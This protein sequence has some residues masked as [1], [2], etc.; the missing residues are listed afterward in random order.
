MIDVYNSFVQTSSNDS[1]YYEG[2]QHKL[3]VI[4]IEKLKPNARELKSLREQLS[5]SLGEGWWEEAANEWLTQ[6]Q[7]LQEEEPEEQGE[8]VASGQE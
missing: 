4:R 2:P 8:E 7:T 1:E 6:K 5:S 3:K